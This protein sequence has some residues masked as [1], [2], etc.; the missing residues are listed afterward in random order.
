MGHVLQTVQKERN[1]R[2][3]LAATSA[4]VHLLDQ[5]K[6]QQKRLLQTEDQGPVF[7]I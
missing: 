4:Q 7:D 3:L 6:A 2:G 1:H 5:S